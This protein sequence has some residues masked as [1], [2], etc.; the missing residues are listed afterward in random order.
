M[1]LVDFSFERTIA[2]VTW[3]SGPNVRGSGANTA[4]D[5]T[6]QTFGTVGD[7]VSFRLDFAVRQD[8][9]ARRS[10]GFLT[11]LGG[12]ANAFRFTYVDADRMAFEEG[13]LTG[14]FEP[15]SWSNGEF[16][17][18][19][20]PWRVN[21]PTIAVAAA[22]VKDAGIVKLSSAFWGHRLGIGDFIGFFPF[23]FGLYMVTEV[24]TPGEYRIWPRLRKAITSN[25]FCTLSPTLVMKA[26]SP[27]VAS[28]KRNAEV[29][30]GMSLSLSEVI[31]PYVRAY[32]EG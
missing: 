28:W 23:H 18:N 32:Y 15:Q 1:R 29:T 16:W 14:P 4:M 31:D 6:E 5:G 19:A 17:A 30:S 9:A 24:I 25:D 21:F 20:T 10:R 3:L 7:V 11:A 27:E 13:G 2:E 12:G 8:M 22:A 26:S